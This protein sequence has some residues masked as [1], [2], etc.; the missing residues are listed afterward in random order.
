MQ[1]FFLIKRGAALGV[2]AS[3]IPWAASVAESTSASQDALPLVV[4][5]ATRIPTPETEVASSVTVVTAEQI[6]ARQIRTLPDLLR[7]IPGLN[8]VQGG[9][10]GAQTSIFLRGTNSNHTKVFIDGIDVGDPSNSNAAFNFGQLLTQDIQRV[11]VLRGPQSGLY[12]SDAVGGV[13]SIITKAGSGPARFNAGIEGGSFN[14]FNQNAGMSGSLDRFHYAASIQHFH[15]GSTPVTPSDYLQPG[16]VRIDDYNDNLTGST[17]LGFEVTDAFDVGLVARYTD[18]HLRFTGDDYDFYPTIPD[19]T[20]S[21]AHTKQYY[22]R[23]TA[24]LSSFG[25]AFEQTLGIAYST[26]KSYSFSPDGPV[27]SDNFGARVKYD[28]QGILAL[29]PTQKLILGAEHQRD[30]I[31]APISADT[32]IDSGYLELQSSFFDSLY[33]TLSVRHDDNDRFGRK[34][35][36]RFA[37]AYIFAATATKLKASVGTGFKAP[38]LSQLFQSFPDLGFFANPN[39]RPETDVGWDAGVEQPLLGSTLLV[40]VTYFHIDIKNLI[41]NSADFT[42]LINVGRA[43]TEGAEA[44]VAYQPIQTLNLRLDY[45]FTQ[46]TDEV[47]H[48]T[49]LRRPKHKASLVSTWQALDRLQL[50]ATV[51]SVS[52]W[53]DGNRDFSI[54]RLNASPYTTVDVA[55]RYSLTKNWDVTARVANLF[56][57]RYQNPDGFDQ[58]TIGAF[59]GIEAKF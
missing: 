6:A 41:G 52:S 35:T 9:G 25:G 16:Q 4:V 58:P 48:R 43:A 13:I 14:T 27:Q 38:T 5:T 51:L 26:I 12:G 3:I 53:V 22:T 32:S 49:L 50:S 42:T 1:S 46:A 8:V 18:A 57:R 54:Q 29:A 33:D 2:A 11:E 31:T 34:T 7:E 44:F 45:T 30:S 40:G 15:A 47:T 10:P 28:W 23:A 24:H 20:Q 17:K 56:N 39:L 19:T 59:A 55:G 21:A 37:P 36:Y